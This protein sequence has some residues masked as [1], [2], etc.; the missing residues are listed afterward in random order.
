MMQALPQMVSKVNHSSEVMDNHAKVI[1]K[2]SINDRSDYKEVQRDDVQSS[3]HHDVKQEENSALTSSRASS[4]ESKNASTLN[5]SDLNPLSSVNLVTQ[6]LN[7]HVDHRSQNDHSFGS[8]DVSQSESRIE[9]LLDARNV[10]IQQAQ[11]LNLSEVKALDTSTLNAGALDASALESN[12]TDNNNSENNILKNKV[13]EGN[14]LNAHMSAL[15]LLELR[16]AELKH[17]QQLNGLRLQGIASMMTTNSKEGA[18]S[19]ELMSSTAHNMLGQNQSTTQ[20]TFQD[21]LLVKRHDANHTA[22]MRHFLTEKVQYQANQHIKE[23]SIRLDPP[24][25]GSIKL[26]VS[27]DAEGRLNVQMQSHVLQTRELLLSLS[28]RMRLDVLSN[29]QFID[30]QVNVG[31]QEQESSLLSDEKANAN[32]TVSDEQGGDTDEASTFNSTLLKA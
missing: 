27:L 26:T 4:Y 15:S 12:V 28:E 8:H 3:H 31:D 1:N 23:L 13:I 10:Q 19:S 18:G 2:N 17:A 6:A 5:Q 20:T 32:H 9:Q 16:T 21:S 30:V 22:D 14:T 24:E 11:A 7:T 29:N 25:L